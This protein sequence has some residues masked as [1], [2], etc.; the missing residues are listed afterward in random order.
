MTLAAGAGEAR[1]G[2]RTCVP[3]VATGAGSEGAIGIRLANA[4]ALFASAYH[5]R[6][7][8][9]LGEGMRR[10][11]SP[12]GLIR[13]REV[14]LLGGQ[15]LLT[16]NRRP[17]RGRVA[18][19]EKLLVNLLVTTAAVA[20]GEP[21]CSD[22]KA[23]V[24]FLLLIRCWLVTLQAVHAFLGMPAHLIFM[25]DGVLRALM[26]LGTLSRGANQLARWLAGFSF[27]TGAVNQKCPDDKA[28]R[29]NNC[30][31]HRSERHW[32]PPAIRLRATRT[33]A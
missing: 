12:A 5:R 21:D 26:A 25:N 8:F 31:E 18:A 23:V 16:I 9:Q 2:D 1:D 3:R 32:G 11:L 33:S 14:H 24:I 7:A 10:A 13:L 20:S 29:N 30:D 15:A 17:R 28:E 4:M 6:R 19:V 22:N 27:G